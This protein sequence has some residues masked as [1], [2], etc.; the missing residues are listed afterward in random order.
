MAKVNG[1]P[2]YLQQLTDILITNY[3]LPVADH[4][5]ASELVRQ[6]A[7][8]KKITVTDKEVQEEHRRTLGLGFGRETSESQ[9]EEALK[10][11]LAQRGITRKQWDMTMRR[12][13]ILRKLAAKQ[14]KITDEILKQEF[15]DRYGRKAQVRLIQLATLAETRGALKRLKNGEDFAK[16]AQK[17]SLHPSAQN[18]GELPPIG[19]K[20]KGIAPALRNAAL[21]LKRVGEISDPVLVGTKFHILRLEKIIEPENVKLKDVKKK[22]V[23]DVREKQIRQI[24]QAMLQKLIRDATLRGD[25]EYV[26]PILKAQAKERSKP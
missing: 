20:T 24:R 14:V 13:A 11:Y 10:R 26:H 3:G 2:I 8:K 23:A 19:S 16:L 22:L 12:N 15:L 7:E 18:G 21:A 25:I 4:L 17:V 5:I 1:R 6:L 9:R